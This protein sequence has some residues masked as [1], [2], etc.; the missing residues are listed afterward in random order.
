MKA[1]SGVDRAFSS[2]MTLYRFVY[3]SPTN[4]SSLA[5]ATNAALAAANDERQLDASHAA[6]QALPEQVS[7]FVL[8]FFCLLS[9]CESLF[10]MRTNATKVVLGKSEEIA[11]ALIA[12]GQFVENTA[13]NVCTVESIAGIE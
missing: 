1:V 6:L 7:F 2:D 4:Q 3:E 9:V 13:T 10:S 8:S 11:A 12:E 5:V